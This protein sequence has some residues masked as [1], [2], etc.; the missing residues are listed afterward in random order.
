MS[1]TQ[2]CDIAVVGGGVIGSAAAWFLAESG[3]AGDVVVIEPDPTYEFATTPQSAGGVRQLFSRPENISLSQ[4]SL[5]FYQHFAARLASAGD[6]PDVGFR[7]Q[8]YLFVVEQDGISTLESNYALQTSMGARAELLDRG[9]LAEKFPS[10]QRDNIEL[11]CYSGDD[12]WID[13]NAALQGFRRGAQKLG[14]TYLQDRVVGMDTG[15][16]SL[17]GVTLESGRTLQSQFFVN[18]AGPWVNEIAEMSDD[19][20]PVRPMC[21][22]QHFW[23]CAHE[24]EPLPLV[25]DE[26][27]LFLRPEGDGFA[28]G[29]PS[30]DIAPGFVDDINY[31]YFADYFER[32]VW[33]MIADLIPKFE[34]IKLQRSW[35]GHYAQ[36]LLDANLIIGPYSK[37]Y[38]NLITACGFSGHGLMHAPA[39]GRALTELALTE[40]FQTLDLSRLGIERVWNNE[41][42]P[43]LGI[44]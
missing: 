42:Y 12:G 1:S 5:D 19:E 20:L 15:G 25:K 22:V 31:G 8:G 33:P 18:T 36:N 7:K 34:D 2:K 29:R 9:A 10:I 38:K 40:K 30:F 37:R 11:G 24:L 13:P 4:F 27:G 21:R 17:R 41:P 14:V 44:K 26:A 3:Q 39:V 28:G 43:E 16:G 35:Q 6:V 32:I 23:H